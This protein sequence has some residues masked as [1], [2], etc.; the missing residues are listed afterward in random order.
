VVTLE[1]S[2]GIFWFD[3]EMDRKVGD[4]LNTSFW[5]DH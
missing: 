1:A 5:S 4:G 2:V 3:R